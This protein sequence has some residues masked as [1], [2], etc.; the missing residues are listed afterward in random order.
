MSLHTLFYPKTIALIGASK[1]EGS[2]GYEIAKNLPSGGYEGKI[3][4]VN[5]KGGK[6]FGKKVLTNFNLIKD[7][8]DL[9]IIA[10]PAKLVVDEVKTLA[11]AR[12]K[13]IVIITSGFKESGNQKAEA[14]LA[15]ICTENNI[16][17]VGPNCL[18][19]LNPEI[20][21]NASFAPLMGTT[22][23]IAFISQSGA[24]CASVLD[25]AARENVGFSKFISIGNKAQTT[26]VE[27]LEYL[28]QDPKTKI[29][30][31]Y[32]EE[33]EEIDLLKLVASKITKGVAAKPII[34]LKAGKTDAG[35]HAAMSHTG[36]LGA[37]DSAYEALFTQTGMI[38][39]DTI[40][41]LFD[42]IECFSRNKAPKN[43]RVAIITNAGGPGVLTADALQSQGLNLAKL[44]DATDSSLKAFLPS[45]ASIQNPIDI[46]GDADSNRYKQT[47]ETVLADKN[48]DA[49]EI[50]LTP[51]S[52]TEV[53]RTAAHIIAL[54]RKSQKPVIVTFLGQGLV[55]AG[56]DLLNKNKVATSYFP[57]SAVNALR[58]LNLFHK[59]QIQKRHNPV[60]YKNTYPTLVRQILTKHLSDSGKLIPT[61]A[62]FNIL[63]AYG[64]P[65]VERHLLLSAADA[66]KLAQNQNTP[67]ALKIISPNINHKTDVGGVV[68]GVDPK[69]IESE[70]Q[71]LITNIEKTVP[72]AQIDGVEAMPM[73]GNNSLELIVGAKSD[74]KLGKQIL[75]GL[76]GIYAEVIR[77]VSW[78]LAPLTKAD[79]KRMIARLK[80]SKIL[81]GYRGSQPLAH[82]KVEEVVGRLSQLVI[83]FPQVKEVDINPLI[84]TQNEATIVDARIIIA[85]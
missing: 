40:E 12:V 71:K 85:R 24:L 21:L 26:E 27:L 56:V 55:K 60:H 28:Y 35:K 49:V 59:W 6:L 52:M 29:I 41:E 44:T 79:I 43:N 80:V 1:D 38:R 42:I 16:T 83:D 15:K 33:F 64:M 68:L 9:A 62:A 8:L 61:E 82:N 45:A 84:I 67:V 3:Y 75:V 22:G 2:V 32:M 10:I 30:A 4:F 72:G 74:K 54:K 37:S 25:Y 18:G 20:K 53:K 31:L 46:L 34:V 58:A 76:G 47:L 57:E 23:E 77:D 50:I 19:F 11:I 17:L 13:S 48:V 81:A 66:A 65:T 14:D 69:N 70:Y 7:I 36:S 63:E 39:A 5:P 73:V 51:Q 78:G